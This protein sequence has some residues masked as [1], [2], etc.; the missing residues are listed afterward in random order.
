MSTSDLKPVHADDDDLAAVA[1]WA[2]LIADV[3]GRPGGDSAL[4]DA[5]TR[6][7]TDAERRRIESLFDEQLSASSTARA[8]GFVTC[9]RSW[10]RQAGG[11]QA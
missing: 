5:L 9:W 7:L 2:R 4:I 3:T 10:H 1:G 6:P 8:R 11:S